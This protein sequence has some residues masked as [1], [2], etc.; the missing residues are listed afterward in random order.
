[1]VGRDEECD[2]IRRLFQRV[3][4]DS[5][6]VVEPTSPALVRPNTGKSFRKRKWLGQ[7]VCCYIRFAANADAT[8]GPQCALVEGEAGMGKTELCRE[9]VHY[10]TGLRMDVFWSAGHADTVSTPLRAFRCVLR[11]LFHEE[12]KHARLSGARLPTLTRLMLVAR[13][14]AQ[15]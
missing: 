2:Q 12:Q 11:G 4:T 3:E 8:L 6:A 5:D 13:P 1:M 9:A 7:S 10:A 14:R 15:R